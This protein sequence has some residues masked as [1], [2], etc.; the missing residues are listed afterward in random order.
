MID[1][2]VHGVLT[3]LGVASI[4]CCSELRAQDSKTELGTED[5]GMK[6]WYA[7]YQHE[8]ESVYR[9]KLDSSD[10]DLT[11]DRTPVLRW[12]NPLEE[13]SIHGVVYVWRQQGRPVVVGQL[14][15][16]LNGKGGRVY[17]H[18]MHSLARADEKL[19]GFRNGKSFWTPDSPGVELRDVPKAPVPAASRPLRLAQMKEIS[20]RFSAETDEATR[21]KRV[22]RLLPTPLDRH[23][24][25]ATNGVDGALFSYV[26]GNDPEVMLLVEA[27]PS[28]TGSVWRYGLCRSTRSS[29]RALLD[30][31]EVWHYDSANGNPSDSRSGYLSVHGIQTLPLTP[32]ARPATKERE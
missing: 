14:F 2:R 24:E 7:F 12:T 18:A 16:Y 28:Q 3:F 9:F 29:C 17:C 21:G 6:A 8:A 30:D 11:L 23:P 15:S 22:L 19:T 32:P 1:H 20:R 10:Q 5:N 4:L 25:N 27:V 13:G 31:L 26:V